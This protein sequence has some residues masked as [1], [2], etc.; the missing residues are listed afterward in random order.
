MFGLWVEREMENFDYD[1]PAAV[2]RQ[3]Q[4]IQRIILK[5]RDHPALLMWCMGNE[6][7]QGADNVKVYDEVNRLTKLA[8][9]LDPNHP[10]S[11]AI[12][13]DSKRAVWL[14]SQ[15]C[16]EVD[17]LAVN[18]YGLTERLAEFFKEG[19]WNKPY[20]ISEYGAPAYWETPL[21]PWGA[22]DE[23]TS[24]QK[25]SYVRTFYQSYIDSRPANCLG[26]YLFYWGTK[27]EESHTWFSVFDEKGRAT[28][29]VE[30]MHELWRGPAPLNLAP[31]IDALLIDSNPTAHY[32]FP[33]SSG[34]HTATIRVHDPEGDSLRYEWEIKLRAQTGTDY[35]G[36]P[37]PS[38]QGLIHGADSHTIRFRLPGQPG[39]YR[40]FAAVYDNHRH[41]ATANFSFNVEK[42]PQ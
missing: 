31:V 33:A 4:R 18:S 38:I 2:E 17:L 20:L 30:L 32:S 11:T 25:L 24:Q 12:S 42:Q 41:V 3:Y 36:V 13:P 21:S 6:W 35:V 10:V 23:P 15:R 1:N 37:R 29:L 22:P 7:A 9:Q 14:V 39:A 27:Q 28:P 34:F 40:L 8:H 19:G 5:Y 16:P 26:A